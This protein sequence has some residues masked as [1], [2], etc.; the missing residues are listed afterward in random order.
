[1]ITN[2]NNNNNNVY[3]IGTLLRGTSEL[4]LLVFVRIP[5]LTLFDRSVD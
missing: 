1:M 3:F 2:N 5:R 4:S